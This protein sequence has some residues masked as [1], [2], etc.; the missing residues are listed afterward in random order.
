MKKVIVRTKLFSRFFF[1]LF[2]IFL[3]YLPVKLQLIKGKITFD[4]VLKQA[5]QRNRNE[6]I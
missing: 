6:F 3:K 2:I 1:A 5:H 4:V